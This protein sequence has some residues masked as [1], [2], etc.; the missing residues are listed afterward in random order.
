VRKVCPLAL[1][2]EEDEETLSEGENRVSPDE[3]V[4]SITWHYMIVPDLTASQLAEHE[5]RGACPACEAELPGAQARTAA[6]VE[7]TDG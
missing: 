3:I 1:A 4:T 6:A 5:K 7:A 2:G